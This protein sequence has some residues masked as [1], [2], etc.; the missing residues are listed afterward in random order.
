M[1]MAA[2]DTYQL[3]GLRA[4]EKVYHVLLSISFAIMSGVTP[5]DPV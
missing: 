5:F 3:S 2:A 4:H 1:I